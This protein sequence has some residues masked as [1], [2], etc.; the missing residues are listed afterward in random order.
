MDTTEKIVHKHEADFHPSYDQDRMAY[1]VTIPNIIPR[2]VYDWILTQN[3]TQTTETVRASGLVLPQ[4]DIRDDRAAVLAVG[5]GSR[6]GGKIVKPD[7]RP[8]DIVMT[9]RREGRKV[10]IAG[11]YYNLYQENEIVMVFFHD[12]VLAREIKKVTKK[13]P[14]SRIRK[15]RECMEVLT[16]DNESGDFPGL[17]ED[18]EV[19]E[20]Y[21]HEDEYDDEDEDVGDYSR[22]TSSSLANE[23]G[24]GIE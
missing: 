3:I 13:H 22:M 23:E 20:V 5:S 15:C 17:C 4:Y 16:E 24:S 11:E 7:V 19:E 1:A 21:Y 8:G 18:C 9:T 14:K 10:Q 6:I 2:P 12:S